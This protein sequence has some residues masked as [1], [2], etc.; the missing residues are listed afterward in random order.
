MCTSSYHFGIME[1]GYLQ[2]LWPSVS[3]DT[4]IHESAQTITLIVT[5]I[6]P[7]MKDHVHVLY[8]WLGLYHFGIV[9]GGLLTK[10]F[11]LVCV[12]KYPSIPAFTT[13][14]N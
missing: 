14:Q 10:H 9:G 3:E 12:K 8:T 4:Y 6:G 1:G 11:D 5:K 13:Q 2:A 7:M